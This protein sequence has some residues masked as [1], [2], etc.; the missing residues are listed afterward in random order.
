MTSVRILADSVLQRE[1]K[2]TAT[3]HRS[4]DECGRVALFLAGP[5]GSCARNHPRLPFALAIPVP[6]MGGNEFPRMVDLHSH[7]VMLCTDIILM[8]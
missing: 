5:L 2:R 1:N 3:G 6:P 8:R 7:E 4:V